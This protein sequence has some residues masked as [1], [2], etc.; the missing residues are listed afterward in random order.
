MTN[1]L[2]DIEDKAAQ[3]DMGTMLYRAY[4]GAIRDGASWLEAYLVVAAFSHG[5]FKA[6]MKDDEEGGDN[7]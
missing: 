3:I 5:M 1:P 6:S 4:E 7:S 2:K